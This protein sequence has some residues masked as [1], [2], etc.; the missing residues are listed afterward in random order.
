MFINALS[1]FHTTPFGFDHGVR[2]GTSALASGH[3]KKAK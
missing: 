1:I 2:A 3:R